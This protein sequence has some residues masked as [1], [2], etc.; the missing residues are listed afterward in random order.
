[1][2]GAATALGVTD[3]ERREAKGVNQC[4]ACKAVR[5]MALISSWV[6][7]GQSSSTYSERKPKSREAVQGAVK[8][9]FDQ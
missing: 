2:G 1:M 8:P 9:V 3:D 7:Q 4:G 5:S 6:D